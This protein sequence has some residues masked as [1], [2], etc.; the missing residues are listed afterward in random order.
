MWNRIGPWESRVGVTRS[1]SPP[2]ASLA[3]QAGDPA[4]QARVAVDP[5]QLIGRE[6]A[7]LGAAGHEVRGGPRDP[8]VEPVEEQIEAPI[9]WPNRLITKTCCNEFASLRNRIIR[10]SF[11]QAVSSASTTAFG[12]C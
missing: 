10:A 12:C 3:L 7:V 9:F 1:Q 8:A 6:R 11:N 4:G 2:F 5:G